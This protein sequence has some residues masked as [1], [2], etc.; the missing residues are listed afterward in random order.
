MSR[1]APC[2]FCGGTPVLEDHR[3]MWAVRCSDCSAC[4]LGDRA[5]E[6]EGEMPESYY[7]PFELTAIERWNRCAPAATGT[8]KLSQCCPGEHLVPMHGTN[9]KLCTGCKTEQ[10]WPLGPGQKPTF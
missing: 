7:A 2:P 10:P 4:V 8:A 9:T 3:L 6:P 1:L 5:P